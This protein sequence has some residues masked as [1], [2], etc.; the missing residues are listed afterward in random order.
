MV[1]FL[2]FLDIIS[3]TSNSVRSRVHCRGSKIILVNVYEIKCVI[4]MKYCTY[5]IGFHMIK[6]A[7]FTVYFLD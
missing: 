4:F 2:G 3:I 5:V 7:W 1:K 6:L